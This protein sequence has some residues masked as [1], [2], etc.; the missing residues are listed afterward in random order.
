M[1][2]ISDLLGGIQPFLFWA[3]YLL[4]AY[5]VI[6]IGWGLWLDKLKDEMGR[7]PT[8]AEAFRRLVSRFRNP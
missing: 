7:T 5:V 8:L 2:S 4:I 1:E 3:A 6:G